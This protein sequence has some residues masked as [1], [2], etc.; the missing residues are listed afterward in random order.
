MKKGLNRKEKVLLHTLLQMDILV[1]KG[2]LPKAI[3]RGYKVN[4]EE[5]KKTLDGF[6]PNKDEE[7]E[8]IDSYLHGGEF[9]SEEEYIE[10]IKKIEL[11]VSG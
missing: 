3:M 9:F 2:F 4:R 1:E 10:L 5:T 6:K 11:L 7:H 8:M